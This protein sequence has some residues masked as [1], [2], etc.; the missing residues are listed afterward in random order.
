[1]PQ[2]SSAALLTLET[3]QQWEG[4]VVG[5]RYVLQDYLGGSDHSAVYVTDFGGIRAVTKLV[6]ADPPDAQTQL[7]RWEAACNL[8]HPNLLRVYE[9]GRWHAN[10]EQDMFFAVMEYADENLGDVLAE[11]P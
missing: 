2:P 4:R 10:D 3:W 1:M 9:T 7:S 11:R 5:G 6:A 8:A